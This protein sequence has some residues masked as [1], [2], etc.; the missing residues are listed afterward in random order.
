MTQFV[1]SQTPLR[2]SLSGGGTDFDAYSKKAGGAVISLAINKYIYVSLK[3]SNPLFGPKFHISYSENEHASSIAEIKNGIVR[4]CLRLLEID[5]P[6]HISTAADIPS[7]SGL[8][9]SS[10]FTV[11]LLNA[12]HAYKGE[13]VTASQLAKEACIVEIERLRKPIGRQDQYATAFGGCNLITFE[14][15]GEISVSPIPNWL[16]EEQIVERLVMV[17]TGITRSADE[18]LREQSDKI[19]KNLQVL[20]EIKSDCLLLMEEINLGKATSSRLA[21]HLDRNW[22]LK[23]ELGSLITSKEINEL[24]LKCKNSG[25]MGGKLL[26]A[27]A[28]GFFLNV[29]SKSHSNDFRELLSDLV[30]VQ[31]KLSHTGSRILLNI[32]GD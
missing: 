19:E 18:V 11:G 23:T 24:Y 9:S 1:T 32:K 29:V 14:P 22:N 26:G 16:D 12:L 17:W 4:E 10:S 21:Q 8:G 27:G 25:S 15:S 13:A 2:V 3:D 31:F 6:L 30:Q 5:N 20:N 7:S 28:G